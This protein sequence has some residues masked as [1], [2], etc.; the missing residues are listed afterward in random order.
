MDHD[1][2]AS[3]RDLRR[4]LRPLLEL[5]LDWLAGRIPETPHHLA[6]PCPE[7]AELLTD[8]V[9]ANR[10]GLLTINSQPGQQEAGGYW[11][12]ATLEA[13]ATPPM[14]EWL[15]M[16]LRAAG[17]IADHWPLERTPEGRG[18][19]VVS[20]GRGRETISLLPAGTRAPDPGPDSST[21]VVQADAH[22][23]A[24]FRG[25]TRSSF[26]GFEDLLTTVMPSRSSTPCGVRAVGCGA[27]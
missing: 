8:L 22:I 15:T 1:V 21:Y 24:A 2:N 5:T 20:T 9:N 19:V 6:P 14:A 11:Q 26:P 25:G 10:R 4:E 12:R 7:T 27:R 23:A 3:D 17:L 18:P 16:R 13:I